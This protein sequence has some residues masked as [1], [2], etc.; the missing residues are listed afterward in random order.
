MDTVLV[1]TNA[2][3]L[4]GI[5][6]HVIRVETHVGPGM[7]VFNV[8]GLPDTSVR[9]SKDRVRA[10]LQSCAVEWFAKRV[11]VNLSPADLPKAGAVFD[12]AIAMGLLGAARA[13]YRQVV[14][15]AQNY[16]EAALVPGVQVRGCTHLS[17]VV[18]CCRN[19]D[20]SAAAYAQPPKPGKPLPGATEAGVDLGDIRGQHE[21]MESLVV[22]AAGGHHLLMIGEPGAGKTMLAR[23][24]PS[25]LPP[26][27]DDQAI[28]TTAVHSLAGTLEPG[29]GLMRIPPFQMPHHSATLPA[30]IGGGSQGLTPGAASLAHH[31]V[32]FLDE[33][34]EFNAHVLDG[35]RQPLESGYVRVHRARYRAQLP[36]RF[37][38]VLAT[39]P[40][41]CGNA[42]SKGKTCKCSSIQ[43]RRYMGRLSGPLMDRVDVHVTMHSPSRADLARPAPYTSATAREKV[44]Q[45]RARAAHRWRE[46][47]WS[48]NAHVPARQLRRSGSLNARACE[49]L[50]DAVG[51]GVLSMRGADRVLRLA[52][53]LA[54]M[55]GRA[56]VDLADIG[57]ALQYRNGAHYGNY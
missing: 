50:D 44:R 39:N 16:A 42:L 21:A 47:P 38:L 53:T 11:T 15:A 18:E 57:K 9:E 35:M 2:V 56:Q 10:A 3:A 5:E 30:I 28:E 48:L 36:A 17:Q 22:T 41:P 12:L 13:G 40:C 20:E 26:L 37:Q 14:V 33:A 4:V 43:L 25:I 7:V 51:R 19:W 49:Y 32:L 46:Y 29:Q 54:D 23:A 52:L 45:A 27:D 34:T 24:L 1:T 31:G 6:A 8:V 55:E